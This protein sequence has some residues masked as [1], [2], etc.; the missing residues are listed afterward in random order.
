MAGEAGRP[1]PRNPPHKSGFEITDPHPYVVADG[2][3]SYDIS[4][5]LCVV[6]LMTRMAMLTTNT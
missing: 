3:W 5:T 6:G 4:P 1:L 2:G